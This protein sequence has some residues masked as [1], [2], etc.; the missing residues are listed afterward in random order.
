MI[1]VQSIAI[2][3]ASDGEIIVAGAQDESAGSRQDAIRLLEIG[4]LSRSTG[5][6]VTHD[7]MNPNVAALN[8]RHS[9][10][11]CKYIA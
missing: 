4:S 7:K 2:R 9:A 5:V 10:T 6:T 1:V 8:P 3:E 11:E